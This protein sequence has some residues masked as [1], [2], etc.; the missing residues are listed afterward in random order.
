M[1]LVSKAWWAW[2]LEIRLVRPAVG[3]VFGSE[4]GST[5]RL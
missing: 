3:L 1:V 5:G 4:A 2:F